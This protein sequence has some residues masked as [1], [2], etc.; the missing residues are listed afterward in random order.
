MK[1][2][3]LIEVHSLA[4]GVT[5]LNVTR[6]QV[7]KA[8]KELNEPDLPPFRSGDIVRFQRGTERYLVA[9]GYLANALEPNRRG[10][11]DIVVISLSSG[12]HRLAAIENLEKVER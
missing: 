4:A 12:L 6:E 10:D 3:V 8:W 7:E 9:A 1:E 2:K 11:K 5:K